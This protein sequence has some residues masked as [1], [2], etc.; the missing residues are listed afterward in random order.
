M[1][2]EFDAKHTPRYLYKYFSHERCEFLGNRDIR[3]TQP[4][5]LNDPFEFR[6]HI[7]SFGDASELWE[8][9][10]QN[11]IKHAEKNFTDNPQKYPKLNLDQFLLLNKQKIE[12][13]TQ[14]A[15]KQ[16]SPDINKMMGEAIRNYADK[17]LGILSLSAKSDNLLMWSHYCASHHGFVVEFDAETKFFNQQ[18]LVSLNM[19]KPTRIQDEYGLVRQVNYSNE[20]PSIVVTKELNLSN[21]LIKGDAWSYEEEFRM[22]MPLGLGRHLKDRLDNGGNQVW[23]FE[24]PP[25]SIARIILGHY[26]SQELIDLALIM[27]N[28]LGHD[29]IKVQRAE[30]DHREYKLKFID[31]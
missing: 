28:S 20:R 2:N 26:A 3:F 19:D 6:P 5:A 8:I 16:L 1:V 25:E 4:N 31:L 18:D 27:R 30:L 9:A 24:V 21:F 29:N 10:H 14:D 23:V 17:N 22:L 15:L 13:M 12:R 11:A 7:S